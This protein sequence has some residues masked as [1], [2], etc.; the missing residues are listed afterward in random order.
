MKKMA[1]INWMGKKKSV[2]IAIEHF[3]ISKV[4]SNMFKKEKKQKKEIK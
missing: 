2:K 3:L 1:K 4:Y